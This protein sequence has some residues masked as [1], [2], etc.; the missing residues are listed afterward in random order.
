L[1][2]LIIAS[3]LFVF[4]VSAVSSQDAG[5]LIRLYEENMLD[6]LRDIL[7]SKNA[8]EEDITSIFLKALLEEDADLAYNYYSRLSNLSSIYG[9]FSNIRRAQYQYAIGNY[10]TASDILTEFLQRYSRSRYREKARELLEICKKTL[11]GGISQA[12]ERETVPDKR[13]VIQ[14]GAFSMRNNAQKRIE[15]LQSKGIRDIYIKETTVLGKKLYT[16]QLR[17]V[18][19][20]EEARNR[21]DDLMRKFDVSYLIKEK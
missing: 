20:K 8:S 13:F 16:I 14:L 1:K 4:F 12:T 3:L 17:E 2:V 11:G 10:Q 6:E 21:G 7:R 19:T 5:Y 15:F 9:E 18:M